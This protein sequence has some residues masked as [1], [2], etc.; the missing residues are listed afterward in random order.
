MIV[1][2]DLSRIG[3]TCNGAPLPQD[4][5]IELDGYKMNWTSFMAAQPIVLEVEYID[6]S[7]PRLVVSLSVSGARM[8]PLEKDLPSFEDL[9]GI[10]AE[11]P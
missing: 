11:T 3:I 8:I 1:E 10:L 5:V 6:P 9:R 4:A 2:V 7:H